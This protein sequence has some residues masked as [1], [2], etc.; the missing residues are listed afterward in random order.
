M[1]YTRSGLDTSSNSSY[2][3]DDQLNTV[4]TDSDDPLWSR[5]EEDGE[6]LTG[7]PPPVLLKTRPKHTYIMLRGNKYNVW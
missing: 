4:D 6:E 5:N 1:M 7:K 2:H 3:S